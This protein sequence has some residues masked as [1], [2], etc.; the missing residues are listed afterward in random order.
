M[1]TAQTVPMLLRTQR[2]PASPG[3]VFTSELQELEAR[4]AKP[5]LNALE[6][7]SRQVEAEIYVPILHAPGIEQLQ[8]Q[9]TQ[10]F[11]RYSSLYS[12]V[13]FLLWSVM[14]GITDFVGIWAPMFARLKADLESHGPD[15]IGEEATNDMLVGLASVGLVTRELLSIAQSGHEVDAEERDVQE[16]QSWSVAHWMATSCVYYYH[17]NREGNWQNVRLLAYWSRYYAIH[18][19]QCAKSLGVIKVPVGK[20]RIRGPSEEDRLLSEAGLED[21][22]EHLILGDRDESQK[23]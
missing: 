23:G 10:R 21:F 13:A 16:L 5:V 19:Y 9:F 8:E 20:G 22:T 18:V 12:S 15:T 3:G 1:T 2:P 17:F 11:Q 4:L 14:P 7:I 6:A